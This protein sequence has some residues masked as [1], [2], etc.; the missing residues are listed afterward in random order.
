[1][2]TFE[3]S[4]HVYYMSENTHMCTRVQTLSKNTSLFIVVAHY[5]NKWL[6]TLAAWAV[7]R[8]SIILCAMLH[9]HNNVIHIAV[10]VPPHIARV[11][12]CA[13]HWR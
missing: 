13:P 7:R 11:E 4:L 1:M 10:H 5:P 8:G 6:V 9:K 2:Y 12:G 3:T